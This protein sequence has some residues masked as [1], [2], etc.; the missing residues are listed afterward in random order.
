MQTAKWKLCKVDRE[1]VIFQGINVDERLIDETL[2]KGGCCRVWVLFQETQSTRRRENTL[3]EEE[4]HGREIGAVPLSTQGLHHLGLR[5]CR[6]VAALT[7]YPCL[8]ASHLLVPCAR[9]VLEPWGL[10]ASHTGSSFCGRP[11]CTTPPLSCPCSSHSCG[12]CCLG[13]DSAPVVPAFL[14]DVLL[15]EVVSDCGKGS[16]WHAMQ[17]LSLSVSLL[18]THP[19]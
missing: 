9:V 6:W 5:Q 16:G 15:R 19:L 1:E 14:L 7:G 13:A 2:P 10:P 4:A 18:V 11:A 17:T 12:S 8:E 3:L